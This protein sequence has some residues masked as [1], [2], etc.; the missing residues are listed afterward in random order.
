[1]CRPG[2]GRIGVRARRRGPERIEIRF[3][4]KKPGATAIAFCPDVVSAGFAVLSSRCN[5]E[6]VQ[7]AAA[8]MTL[9]R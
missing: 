8:G 3:R 5:F 7:K 2:F 4:P 6:L 9:F 1:M